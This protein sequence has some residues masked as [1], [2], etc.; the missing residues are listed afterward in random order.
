M[1]A[2]TKDEAKIRFSRRLNELLEERDVP[3]RGRRQ[4]L[5]RSFN[6]QFSAEAARKWLEAESIP[7]QAHLAMLCTSFGWSVDYLMT[8]IGPKYAP[9]HDERLTELLDGWMDIDEEER[10]S[11][12]LQLRNA[13][14]LRKFRPGAPAAPTNLQPRK[15]RQ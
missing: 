13:R 10:R 8:G 6:N 1:V 15:R 9:R 4:W 12:L 2:I 11:L 5:A 3:T 7:D 14:D